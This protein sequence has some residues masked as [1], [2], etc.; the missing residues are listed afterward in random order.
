MERD[1]DGDGEGGGEAEAAWILWPSLIL[2]GVI[3]G[4]DRLKVLGLGAVK[5]LFAVRSAP[6][7]H[8]I[9]PLINSTVSK[10]TP[11]YNAG[12]QDQEFMLLTVDDNLPVK[13]VVNLAA[14]FNVRLQLTDKKSPGFT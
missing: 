4:E 9:K 13:S 12:G 3:G 5:E 14:K 11:G 1:G 6:P 7:P 10:E 8:R 2:E